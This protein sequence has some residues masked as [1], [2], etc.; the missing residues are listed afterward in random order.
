MPEL[1]VS[2]AAKHQCEQI[3]DY[4]NKPGQVLAPFVFG[5]AKGSSEKSAAFWCK[6]KKGD[7]SYVSVL[8]FMLVDKDWSIH[9]AGELEWINAAK[10][11]SLF[12]VKEPFSEFTKLKA[13]HQIN[14]PKAKGFEGRGVSS[15]YDGIEETFVMYKGECDISIRECLLG[16][17]IDNV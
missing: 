2:L 1:L 3:D 14:M 17:C 4:Y 12:S 15:S 8:M 10:G 16:N 6:R 13:E 11:L 7:G 9:K 5:V